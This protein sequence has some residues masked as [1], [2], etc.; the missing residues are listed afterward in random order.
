MRKGT[1]TLGKVILTSALTAA[2]AVGMGMTAFA[3][4]PTTVSTDDTATIDNK[5]HIASEGVTVP[6]VTYTYTIAGQDGAPV[7]IREKTISFTSS[8]TISNGIIEKK[9]TEVFKAVD[10]SHTGV[11]TY[12]LTQSTPS[13]TGLANDV[14]NVSEYTVKVKVVTDTTG[15]T[16][17]LKISGIT[18]YKTTAGDTEKVDKIVF[19]NTYEKTSTLKVSK[20]LAGED[21]DYGDEF[22][23][24]I[25]F[26]NP[27]ASAN[28]NI[29]DDDLKL[30]ASNKVNQNET[31]IN[32]G[33]ALAYDTGYTFVL[34]GDED[35]TFNVPAGIKYTVTESDAEGYTAAV[36]YVENGAD[37]KT[38]TNAV[39]DALAGENTNTVE[40]TN[41]K[42]SSPLTGLFTENAPFVAMIAVAGVAF[43]A[44]V[45]Y[46]KRENA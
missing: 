39:T 26:T 14:N 27:D 1:K 28:V 7:S 18:A 19:D 9:L 16:P 24:T 22:T 25:T 41:T 5:L 3:T 46:K 33:V 45:I 4:E 6:M 32:A 12:K 38:G 44:Y 17:T 30:T 15:E 31:E 21:A 43:V 35:I 42:A 20:K 2:M 8:D 34:K 36:S 40:F 10:F 11:Y 23:Y 29:L 13:V 37:A